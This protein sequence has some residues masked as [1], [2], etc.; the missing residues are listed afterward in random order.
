MCLICDGG[1][2]SQLTT[3]IIENCPLITNITLLPNLTTLYCIKLPLLTN[4]P[5]L[6]KLTRLYYDDCPLLTN[7]PLLPNLT[8]LYCDKLP[9]ITNLP[10]LPS[11]TI[12]ECSN[13]P[14][15]PIDMDNTYDDNI[16]NLIIL[17][18]WFKK[19]LLAKGLIRRSI[20]IA[21]YW[22]DPNAHGGFF[23]K[24]HMLEYFTN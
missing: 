18:R 7:I 16:Q 9:L 13:C 23:H 1:D 5:L 8:H 15:L 19:S 21:P 12:I 17:Q 20:Q 24:K 3:L 22:Y 6:P 10:I 2:L 4:I 14:W 11:V